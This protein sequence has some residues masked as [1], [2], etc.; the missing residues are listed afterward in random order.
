MKQSGNPNALNLSVQSNKIHFPVPKKP[1]LEENKTP[2][3]ISKPYPV[4]TQPLSLSNSISS[5]KHK[6]QK[7]EEVI[8]I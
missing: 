7:N 2:L 8:S 4:P 5:Y 6:L 1:N 3:K